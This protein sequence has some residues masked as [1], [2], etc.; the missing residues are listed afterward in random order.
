MLCAFVVVV[1]LGV[2]GWVV[3]VGGVCVC[4]CVFVCVVLWCVGGWWWVGGWF[5]CG[6]LCVYGLRF[7]R[8]VCVWLVCEWEGEGWWVGG[9]KVSCTYG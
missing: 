9:G 1:G 2:G 3:E 7:V 6:C 5:L 4:V 8:V